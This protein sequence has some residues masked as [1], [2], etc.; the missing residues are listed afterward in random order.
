MNRQQR[1]ALASEKRSA[2]GTESY[3]A[4]ALELHRQGQLRTAE[5]LYRQVLQR[6]PRQIDALH[7]LGVLT[8]QQSHYVEAAEWIRQAL[9]IDPHYADAWNNLGNV[10]AAM[11]RWGEAA[12]AYQR[13]NK[14]AP[15]N[16]S[17]RCNLGV[18]LL[19]AQRPSEAAVAFRDAIALEPGLVEAHFNL[20]RALSALGELDQAT[21]AYQEVIRLQPTH[22]MAYRSRG[23]LLYRLERSDEAIAMFQEWLALQPD[24]PV[25]RHMLAAHSGQAVPERAADHYVQELFDGMAE[26]FDEHLHQ[27]EYRAPELIASAVTA[28]LGSPTG[29]LKIL[30]AG[31]G[32]GLCGPSLR[33]YA[34]FLIGVDLSPRMI[35]R[36]QLRGDYDEL[37]IAE[38]TAFLSEHPAAYDV[39]VSAD[40]L[41]YFGALEPILTAAANALRA[42]GWL[43]FTVEQQA[44][45]SQTASFTLDTSGRYRH[46][47]TYVRQVLAQVGLRLNALETVTLRLEAGQPVNGLLVTAGKPSE[48]PA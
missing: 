48:H 46:S 17:A 33:A 44:D 34:E 4:Q 2:T 8:A 37:A 21:T 41:V 26:S 28:R 24:N 23:I 38:L 15:A 3:L 16:A 13:A 32:T 10:L 40:T 22:I 45:D 14:L 35:E 19:R 47:E 1:R 18:I 39:I 31:C 43:V 42:G 6:N 9:A 29:L 27:L 36:A 25:A 7:F 5:N 11:D 30:D 20:G 12:D